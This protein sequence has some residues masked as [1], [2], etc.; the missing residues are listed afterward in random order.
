MV[1]CCFMTTETLGLLGTGAQDGHLD[2]HSSWALDTK[3]VK[4]DTGIDGC[5]HHLWC[6]GYICSSWWVSRFFWDHSRKDFSGKATFSLIFRISLSLSLCLVVSAL[7]LFQEKRWDLLCCHM[8]FCPLLF[9]VRSA[10][11][12]AAVQMH[13]TDR[14]LAL[15][16][17]YNNIGQCGLNWY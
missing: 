10:E 9:S 14:K 7:M 12:I 5:L 1:E 8:L 6:F 13:G 16:L 4:S 15:N 17:S 2:S 3:K 11:F